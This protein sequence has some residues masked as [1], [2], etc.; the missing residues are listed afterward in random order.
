MERWKV[1]EEKGKK[2]KKERVRE[3]ER[4]GGEAPRQMPKLPAPCR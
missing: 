1:R 4:K 2:Q 3:K